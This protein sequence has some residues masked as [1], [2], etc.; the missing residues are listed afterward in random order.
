M[1]TEE[2]VVEFALTRLDNPG[3]DLEE[4][5]A[6]VVRRLGPEGMMQF[7]SQNLAV[8]D[9][10]RGGAFESAVEYVVRTVLKLRDG[11]D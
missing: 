10:L 11:D 6:L 1:T 8:R 7:A 5:A 3:L 2:L 9:E 4:T